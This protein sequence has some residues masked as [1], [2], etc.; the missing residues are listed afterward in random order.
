MINH[1]ISMHVQQTGG[2]RGLALVNQVRIEQ[3][4]VVGAFLPVLLPKGV[5]PVPLPFLEGQGL[6]QKGP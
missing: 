4:G 5:P 2:I 3:M 1:I 6:L